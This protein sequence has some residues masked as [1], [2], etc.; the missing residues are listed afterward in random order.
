MNLISINICRLVPI[1]YMSWIWL[2][3]AKFNPSSIEHVFYDLDFKVILL[4]GG[5]LEFAHLIEF[6]ILYVFLIVAFL[7]LGPLTKKKEVAALIIAIT[8]SFIDEIHQYYVPYR[9]FSQID[10]VKNL[11]GIWFFWW[12]VRR[13]Y[14]NRN[15]KL[16]AFFRG[17]Q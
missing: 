14:Y 2:Q 13:T 1:I 5:T 3:S 4:I 6:G 12:L 9:S 17:I 16:G 11:I 15:S 7:T 8:Y 10:M